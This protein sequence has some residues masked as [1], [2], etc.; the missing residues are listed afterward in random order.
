LL[1]VGVGIWGWAVFNKPS[2]S[3]LPDK[4]Q[5]ATPTLAQPAGEVFNGTIRNIL[6]KRRSL[7]CAGD[8]V[9]NGKIQKQIV[10]CDGKNL[11]LDI[12]V[13]AGKGVNISHVII[14]SDWQYMW[15]GAGAA[16]KAKEYELQPGTKELKTFPSFI[17]NVAADY[18][19]L[20]WTADASMFE[21]P[22]ELNFIAV[23][24]P[25]QK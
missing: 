1:L 22:S 24:G 25:E 5:A 12:S 19:C 7:R 6:I 16:V 21:I 3:N 18:N 20:P 9:F 10:Y 11:R 23:T 2:V 17:P 13:D 14:S 4:K 15:D 8:I